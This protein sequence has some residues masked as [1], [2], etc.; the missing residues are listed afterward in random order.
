[1]MNFD[2]LLDIFNIQILAAGIMGGFVHSFK[3][4]NAGPWTI[5][6]YISVGGITAILL[7]P[8]LVRFQFELISAFVKMQ[9][10]G[11]TEIPSILVA[12]GIGMCGRAICD[13]IE[14]VV[15]KVLGTKRKTKNE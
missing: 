2:A 7:T 13:H 10:M 6:G 4:K 3:V 8:Y 14:E 1:M 15:L 9:Q 12:F 11:V 5:I